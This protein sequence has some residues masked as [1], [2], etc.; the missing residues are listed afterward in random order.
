MAALLGKV[1]GAVGR[2]VSSPL[3][4]AVGGLIGRAGSKAGPLIR[5]G[6]KV[7]AG[8]AAFELGSQA[9]RGALTGG[10]DGLFGLPLVTEAQEVEVL[11]APR[12][13]VLIQ[14]P[15]SDDPSDKVA[16]L[17]EVAYALGLRKRPSRG[18]ISAREIKAARRVQSVI[19]SLTVKR[20]PRVPI[21]K[22]K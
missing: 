6:A 7:A 13:Y 5:T 10:G 22:H 4:K 3:G 15:E 8:G 12:G 18:G 9:V 17:K 11:R 21:K 19:M 16:V 1:V 2:A 20:V 14:N